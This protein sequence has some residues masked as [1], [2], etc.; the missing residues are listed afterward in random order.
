MVTSKPFGSVFRFIGN[1]FGG[2]S[3]RTGGL[4]IVLPELNTSSSDTDNVI[5]DVEE[6]SPQGGGTDSYNWFNQ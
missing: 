4:E 1:A 2:D 6:G 5:D 3:S